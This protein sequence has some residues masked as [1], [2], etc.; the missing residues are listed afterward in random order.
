MVAPSPRIQT[1]LFLASMSILLVHLAII[2]NIT[3]DA[4]AL[5]VRLVRSNSGV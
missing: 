3:A 5:A 1:T 4:A 2:R